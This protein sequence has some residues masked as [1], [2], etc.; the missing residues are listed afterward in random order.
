MKIYIAG[1]WEARARLKAVALEVT[2]LGH[3]VTASWL[4][5]PDAAYGLG[6][7]EAAHAR[8]DVRDVCRSDM[9]ILDTLNESHT[10]GREFEAGLMFGL[11]Q[12]VWRVGPARHIFHLL[13]HEA[14]EDWIACIKHLKH[15][16]S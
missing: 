14:F 9:L 4:D 11:T 8:E 5:T 3:E 7:T 16:T 12:R 1:K 10:G 15:A 13:A 6:D 2:E